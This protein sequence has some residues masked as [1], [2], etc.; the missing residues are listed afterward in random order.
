MPMM[1][2]GP[3]PPVDADEK[4]Q[5]ICDG[6]KAKAEEQAG[7]TYEVFTAKSYMKQVVSGTNYFIKVHVGGDDHLHLRV[8]E[9][10]PCHGGEIELTEMQQ[11]KSHQ[12][13]IEYF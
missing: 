2:G 13:P 11:S 9:R 1:C 6:V 7:K 10:L 4:I 5:T 3:S 12:D 8:Y